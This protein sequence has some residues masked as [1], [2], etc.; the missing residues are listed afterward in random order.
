MVCYTHPTHS[1]QPNPHA[2]D[3]SLHTPQPSVQERFLAGCC[4]GSLIHL[5]VAGILAVPTAVYLALAKDYRLAALLAVYYTVRI[6]HPTK[7]WAFIR[8]W[9][10]E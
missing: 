4:L 5:W 10:N 3:T 6:V 7:E 8:R 9:V 1:N 2:S